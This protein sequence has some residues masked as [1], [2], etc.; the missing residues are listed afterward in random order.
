MLNACGWGEE[1]EMEIRAMTKADCNAI[2]ELYAAAW[3]AGYK[4][5]LP[6]DFLDGITSEKYAERSRGLGFLNEGSFVVLDGERIV[7]HCHARAANEPEWRG[8]GEIHTLYVHPE[9]WRT[10]Y[11]A[12]VFKR[13]EEWLYERGFDDVYLYVLE[14][15]KRAE[16]FY[17]AQGFFPNGGTLCCEIGGVTVTDNR[18]TK[19]YPRHTEYGEAEIRIAES[20]AAA[21]AGMLENGGFKAR[22][23]LLF[24][25]DGYF[26]PYYG[27]TIPERERVVEILREYEKNA[28][29]STLFAV[30]E[31]LEYVY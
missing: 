17:K 27:K 29:D 10:G 24:C 1:N 4:G 16:R 5:L 22:S 25:L 14:G 6:Q 9:Y 11:G 28:V 20:G 19:Y 31:L 3:K 30:R 7:G 8:W 26:D 21:I 18:Y 13:A 15:N 12:A 23:S 2:G